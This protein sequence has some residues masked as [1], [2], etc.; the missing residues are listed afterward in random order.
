MLITDLKRALE[1][2]ELRDIYRIQNECRCYVERRMDD[3][4]SKFEIQRDLFCEGNNITDEIR[5]VVLND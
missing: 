4:G 1:K 5:D 2:D 3:V